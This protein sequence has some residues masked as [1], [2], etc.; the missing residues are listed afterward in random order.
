MTKKECYKIFGFNDD[1]ILTEQLIKSTY[2][3]LSKKY[4]PDNNS[5]KYATEQ[6]YKVNEA[7]ESLINRKFTEDTTERSYQHNNDEFQKMYNMYRNKSNEAE[8]YRKMWEEL[9]KEKEQKEQPSYKKVY[10]K[11]TK[12]VDKKNIKDILFMELFSFKKIFKSIKNGF[13]FIGSTLWG[14]LELLF[15][16]I[17]FISFIGYGYVIYNTYKNVYDIVTCIIICIGIYIL[18]SILNFCKKYCSNKKEILQL[19]RQ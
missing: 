14:V 3:K 2:R 4:H 6:L 5:S 9:K 16:I 13:L 8:Y 19:F 17:Y 7:Y 11:N 18:N 15:S 1:I 12:K 10:N